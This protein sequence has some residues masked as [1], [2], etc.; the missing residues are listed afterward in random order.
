MRRSARL[1]DGVLEA[2]VVG[3]F[4]KIGYS[5]RRHLYDFAEPPRQDGRVAV[6][7]GATSGL[8]L[9]TATQ[10][11]SLGATTYLWAR[12]DERALRARAAIVARDDKADVRIV[13]GDMSDPEAIRSGFA[14]IAS[15]NDRLDILV[16]NAGAISEHYRRSEFGAEETV[17]AQLLGPFLLTTLFLPLLRRAEPGRVIAVSSGGLYAERFNL[18]RM[19]MS[20]GDYDGVSAYARVKRAQFVIN[21][22]WSRRIDPKDVVFHAMHPGWADTPGVATSLPRFHRLMAPLLRSAAQGADTVVW[23]ATSEEAG[24]GSGEFWLDRRPRSGYK[25]P[26]TR[27]SD[28]RGDGDRLW[29]WCEERVN[30]TPVTK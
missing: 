10:L 4:S 21:Q 3:S 8:G 12:N 29:R 17:A 7:T 19:E 30:G 9:E 14:K 28:P 11:A 23:L 26:W 22:E 27:S 15:E 18:A 16:H 5:T 2:T 20:A 1:V 6:V 13:I 25:L 24:S